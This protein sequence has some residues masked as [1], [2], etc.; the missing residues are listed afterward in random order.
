MVSQLPKERFEK[1]TDTLLLTAL[2]F[3][4]LNAFEPIEILQEGDGTKR[5]C[6]SVILEDLNQLHT[7]EQPILEVVKPFKT[8]SGNW[9]AMA[10]VSLS[11]KAFRFVMR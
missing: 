3:M 9:C 10:M 6:K 11:S 2:E 5:A 4:R 8:L 1:E 7:P